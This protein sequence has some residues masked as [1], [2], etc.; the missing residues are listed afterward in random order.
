MISLFINHHTF[1]KLSW[2]LIYGL[3]AS[4]YSLMYLFK[5]ADFTGPTD[6]LN[7]NLRCK[8][9]FSFFVCEIL[10]CLG[11]FES[12][13]LKW[14]V[15]LSQSSESIGGSLLSANEGPHSAKCTKFS[16]IWTQCSSQTWCWMPPCL[17]LCF[18][19]FTLFS[20]LGLPKLISIGFF[21]ISLILTGY[22]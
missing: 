9:R 22:M 21:E 1:L 6:L 19:F 4:E 11:K 20:G 18:G 16:I 12:Y 7:Q 17:N 5:D 3:V 13:L 8:M 14:W 10:K 2:N 15:W